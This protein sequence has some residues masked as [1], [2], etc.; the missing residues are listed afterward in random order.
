MPGGWAVK[1]AVAQTLEA[2]ES[3]GRMGVVWHT[4]GSGTSLEMLAEAEG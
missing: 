1:K 2:V 3:D 4:Q